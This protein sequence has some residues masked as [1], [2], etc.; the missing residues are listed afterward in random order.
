MIEK[1]LVS[2]LGSIAALDGQFWP[3][4][5]PVGDAEPPFCLYTRISG[6][7]QRDL[8]GEPVFYRDV[9]RCF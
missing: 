8:T 1:F 4:A 3:V 6:T 9:Y 5:A 7:I 2:E